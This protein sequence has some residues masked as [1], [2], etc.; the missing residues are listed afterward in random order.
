MDS[1]ALF[2]LVLVVVAVAGVVAYTK[3][4][5]VTDPRATIWDIVETL[6]NLDTVYLV[7]RGP[8]GIMFVGY[9]VVSLFGGMLERF[10][11]IRHTPFYADYEILCHG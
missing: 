6:T 3:G 11:P 4:D 9:L 8:F 1:R 10:A 7:L 5:G 2:D